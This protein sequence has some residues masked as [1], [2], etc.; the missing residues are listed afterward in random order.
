MSKANIP[1]SVKVQYIDLEGGFWGM[2]DAQN[3]QYL[4]VNFP[5]QM[6]DTSKI[7]TITYQTLDVVGIQMWGTP[8][9]ITSF[10]T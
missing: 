7:Y 2:I 8:I 3:Q 9:Q 6:K 4:A 5:E 10:T 1:I